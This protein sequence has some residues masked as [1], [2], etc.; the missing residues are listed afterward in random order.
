MVRSI[1]I[2]VL[3]VGIIGI[4]YWGYKENEDKN[5]LLIQ[6]ENTY[7]RAFHELA[8]HMDLLHDKIGTS[9]A[10][11]TGQRLSPQF[12]DIWR[13][14]SNA[15]SDVSQLPLGLVPINETEQFL[16]DI[17]DFTYKTAIRNLDDDPLT[18]KEMK[19]LKG[20]YT[21]ASE[22]KDDLREMQFESLN[23]GL[24]W[25]DV[26]LALATQNTQGDNTI[27][28][29]FESV[30]KKVD[31]FSKDNAD[32][33]LMQTAAKKKGFKNLSGNWSSEQDIIRFTRKL[34]RLKEDQDILLTKSGEGAQAPMFTVSYEDG[35]TVYMDIT[36]KGAH[37]V[38]I[39]VNRPIKEKQ[40]SLNEGMEK[41]RKYLDDFDYKDMEVFQSQEFNN[42][43]V[44][45]FVHKQDDV[46]I[47]PDAVTVKVAL[48]DGEIVGLT[49]R[50]YL[51]NHHERKINKPKLSLEEAR[52][53]VNN[54]VDIQEDHVAIIENDIEEEV[55]AYEFLGTM[56]DETYRVFINAENGHEEKVEK[57]TGTETNFEANL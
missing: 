17:G 33:G 41:A 29:G 11:N 20:L 12:V 8:Y 35:K 16:S 3:A 24:R 47:Y 37:P 49:A 5:A 51:M 26:E 48:D 38:D 1:I 10:M 2:A 44:F 39:I 42:T 40:I 45:S 23:N 52:G 53:F 31:G 28:D 43:G 6:T 55:L 50:N 46:R 56:D 54:Q 14:S 27:V 34:F 19:T 13:I 21:Q 57:L 15:L 30:E 7:Q 32:A 25:M 9:L 4:G 18:E 36:Q 22:L